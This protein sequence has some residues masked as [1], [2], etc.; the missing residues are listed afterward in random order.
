MWAAMRVRAFRLYFGSS[1]AHMAAVNVQQMVQPWF[2]YELTGS[3]IMLGWAALANAIPM[4]VFSPVG[5]YLADRFPKRQLLVLAQSA[6]VVLALL[7]AVSI[8]LGMMTPPILLA[9]AVVQGTL[10]TIMMPARQ[11]LVR[12]IVD[13]RSLGNALALSNAGMN[14][15]RLM[16]PAA[17]G[18]L[19]GFTGAASG[20]YAISLSYVFGVIMTAQLPRTAAPVATEGFAEQMRSALSYVR[21]DRTI[22]T[23]LLITLG[24]VVMSMPYITL[25]PVFAKDVLAIDPQRLGLLMTVSGI[26]ALAASLGLAS[27]GD[28]NRGRLY[29][30]STLVLG[31]ALL[32]FSLTRSYP[33]AL[34]FII[35]LGVGQAGRMALGNILIQAYVD[36]AYRG[37]VMSL[38]LMEFGLTSLSTFAVSG[39][40]QAVGV[41]I[42]LSGTAI[43]LILFTVVL[44]LFVPLIRRL[45]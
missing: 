19:I 30:M 20:Y 44:Y 9:A 5:G 38:F 27:I 34:L 45:N 10:M 17:T 24:G 22:L 7:I 39:L 12:E 29:M 4:L 23:I 25:L 33:L 2:M 8:T 6:S 37:R 16:A 40:A 3:P 15:N 43:A 31:V 28:H 21:H 18:L 42:A 36:D 41:D 32:L 35:P 14:V 1:M 13:Y 11:A 26:G